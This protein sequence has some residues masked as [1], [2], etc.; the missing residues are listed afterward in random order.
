MA[1]TAFFTHSI[2]GVLA[3]SDQRNNSKAAFNCIP[4]NKEL[5]KFLTGG[6]E[7]T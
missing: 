1:N 3:E 2:E 6:L 7:L 4:P 5:K